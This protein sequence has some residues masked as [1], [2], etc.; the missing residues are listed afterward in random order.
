M[1]R[2]A[3]PK[4]WARVVD[5]DKAAG[6]KM[7]ES[8]FDRAYRFVRAVIVGGGATAIDFIV[9]TSCIRVIGLA[10]VVARVPALIAGATFQFFGN[11]TFAFRAQAGS[12][13]RQAKLFI[14][15]ELIALPLNFAIFRWL[16]PRVKFVPPEVISFLGT[17]IVFI[18]FGYPMRRL[19]IFRIPERE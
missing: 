3:P 16:V 10:P 4:I 8:L 19:V 7:R 6:L 12:I 5:G 18:T 15:A 1:P 2:L 17:F 9:L 14:A 11:R 13:T